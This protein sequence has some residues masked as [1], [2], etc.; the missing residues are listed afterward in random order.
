VAQLNP[1]QTQEMAMAKHVDG[2]FLPVPKKNLN[3]LPPHG[4]GLNVLNPFP[5]S[6]YH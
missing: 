3:A 6:S 1:K 5:R 4:A 2:F